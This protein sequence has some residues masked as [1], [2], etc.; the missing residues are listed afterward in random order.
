MVD[1]NGDGLLDIYV[2]NAGSAQ[3]ENQKELFI[4]NGDGTFSDK[5]DEYN[6]ADTGLLRSARK[7]TP[8][9]KQLS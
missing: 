7:E 3:G 4:N 1:I 2:C 6:L 9:P 8:E 5:A